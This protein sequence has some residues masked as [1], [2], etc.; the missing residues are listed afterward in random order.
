MSIV[1]TMPHDQKY[2]STFMATIQRGDI[3]KH[4]VFN[5]TI[6]KNLA[7][8][9][10]SKIVI[11]ST[12]NINIFHGRIKKYIAYTG[13]AFIEYIHN[14]SAGF[15][16]GVNKIY[17]INLEGHVSG[18]DECES[19][20]ESYSTI[21]TICP[22]RTVTLILDRKIVFSYGVIVHCVDSGNASNGFYGMVTSYDCSTGVIVIDDI[23][24]V[25]GHFSR[26]AVFR[27]SV[28]DSD[29][30]VS[31]AGSV[32][33]DY[34]KVHVVKGP[35]GEPGPQGTQ[36]ATGPQGEH[37]FMGPLGDPGPTGPQGTQ[38]VTGPRGTQGEP[39]P[40]GTQGVT[41]P[42]GTQ[43]EPGLQGTQGEPGPQGTQG[44]T[45][46]QGTQGEPGPQGTQG[47][48]GPQGTQGEP[49]PQGTQGEPGPQGTQGTQ[50]VT[51]PQ[52]TQGATGPQGDKFNTSGDASIV[53]GN[54]R[55]TVNSGLAYIPGNSVVVVNPNDVNDRF[56]GTV[57]AYYTESGILIIS[58]STT[59]ST[60]SVITY[61]VNLDSIDGPTGPQGAQGVTGP[62]GAQGEIGPQGTQGVTG[63]QG[64]QGVTGPQGTQGEI[65]PQGTQGEIGPQ[66]TQGVTGP[67]GTQGTQG[68]TGPTG[69]VGPTG[70]IGSIGPTG[71]AVNNIIYVSSTT[72]TLNTGLPNEQRIVVNDNPSGN[73]VIVYAN[74]NHNLSN[75]INSGN[76]VTY[77]TLTAQYRAACFMYYAS[78]E[79]W[80]R[81]Y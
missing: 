56:E 49:G 45:G 38:G 28:A 10:G 66:G 75:I 46:P 22:P 54:I 33:S 70:A 15:K 7:F 63:P 48:P 72:Y 29:D 68:Q 52:G 71:P 6:G 25:S 13:V 39:G 61:N 77:I 73:N 41:G 5:A 17:R 44:V 16:Y 53:D 26:A 35:K 62:Q 9:N 78:A 64:T 40:Q 69:I 31:D 30:C 60:L 19:E 81:L 14:I 76:A 21:A 8:V 12:D 51:G 67:Q 34:P 57:I 58:P 36:G 18:H 24:N 4:V 27:V 65:G 79:V 80:I 32:C 47:E 59:M 74:D 23:I 50:G 20:N 42:Q 43:G 3:D 2:V 1:Y 55:I 11:S 37:G